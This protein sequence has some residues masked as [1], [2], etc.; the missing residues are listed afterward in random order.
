MN[1][2]LYRAVDEA[3]NAYDFDVL[4]RKSSVLLTLKKQTLEGVQK[5]WAL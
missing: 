4:E 3:G 1:T 5:L 2:F